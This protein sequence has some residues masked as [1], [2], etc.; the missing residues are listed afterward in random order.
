MQRLLVLNLFISLMWPILNNDYTFEA[1]LLGFIFGFVLTSL[2]QRRYG[3]YTARA[4][5][6]VAYVLLAIL[7]SNLRLA[8]TVLANAVGMQ[9]ALRPGIVAVPLDLTNSFDITVLATVITLTPGTL[10][11]DLGEDVSGRLRP[12]GEPEDGAIGTDPA[13]SEQRAQSE[14]SSAQVPHRTTG[15]RNRGEAALLVH[16][17][18][19]SDPKVFRADIKRRFEGPL[20]ELRRLVVEMDSADI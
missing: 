18:D 8:A 2:V 17:I 9:T 5:G 1:L 13:R 14:E 7:Q 6:F 12:Y 16:A 15:P 10:S 4:A 19:V 3:L 20:L 11:V